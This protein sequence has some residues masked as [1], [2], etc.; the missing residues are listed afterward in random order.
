MNTYGAQALGRSLLS[1][2]FTN[3]DQHLG[4]APLDLETVFAVSRST[5]QLLTAPD[6]H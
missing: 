6:Y 5:S 2:L 4:R 1:L 3:D